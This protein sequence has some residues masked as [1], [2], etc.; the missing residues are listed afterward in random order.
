MLGAISPPARALQ[1]ELPEGAPEAA[2]TPLVSPPLGAGAGASVP[3]AR[4]R[5][6][7]PPRPTAANADASAALPTNGNREA[8]GADTTALGDSEPG[9]LFGG[10]S[11]GSGGRTA[12]PTVTRRVPYSFS[13]S[14]SGIYD[15]NISLGSSGTSPDFSLSIVP[16]FIFG[17]D[18]LVSA[19]GNYLHFTYSPVFTVYVENHDNNSVQHLISLDTQYHFGRFTLSARQ[20]VQI[21]DGTDTAGTSPGPGALLQPGQI[22]GATPVYPTGT[23]NQVN[24]DVSGRSRLNLYDTNLNVGFAYSDKTSFNGGL[25]Y[26]ISDYDG[27]ISSQ[28]LAG[29]LYVNYTY[30][31]K[32]VISGGLTGGHAFVNDPSP[33][34]NFLQANLRLSYRYSDKL[35]FAGSAGVEFRQ[36]EDQNR[37]DITPVFDLGASYRPFDGTNVSV[38][39]TRSV[40]SS[41]VLAGQN[42]QSTGLTISTQQLINSRFS[43][44]L[45]LGYGNSHYVSVVNSVSADRDENYFAVQPLLN[46]NLRPG[47]V[48]SLF[49]L[50]RQNISSGAAARRFS[51]NQA[52]FTASYAF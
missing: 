22:A 30:S 51:N 46:I 43:A 45:I 41:A 20:S 17:L 18:N 10:G 48:L 44:G 2:P 4:P 47:L 27:L 33:D 15:N 37:L 38:T 14:L 49:Y 16:T 12:V 36:P 9:A 11:G 42:F 26:S 29:S 25:Q 7:L 31:L 24:L 23:I 1:E 3:P 32:T 52:G 39:A 6:P 5:V 19:R 34:Q 8:A 28:T 21:L 50:H 13:V 35:S 40:Q